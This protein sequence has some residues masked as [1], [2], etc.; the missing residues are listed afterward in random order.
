MLPTSPPYI[1]DVFDNLHM[2]WM[3]I[4]IN[5]HEDEI[6]LVS[7]DLKSQLKSWITAYWCGMKHLCRVVEATNP[8]GML[9]TSPPYM[10]K[11]FANLHMLCMGIWI[12]HNPVITLL[13]GPDL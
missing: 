6:M 3:G 7:P 9:S 4:W 11:V 1:S 8:H 2:L 5:N 12:S 13:V 10:S